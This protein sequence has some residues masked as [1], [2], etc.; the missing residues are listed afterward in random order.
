AVGF[1]AGHG[2][3]QG[4]TVTAAG[5]TA[6]A[7][8]TSTNGGSTPVSVVTGYQ[9]LSST[10]IQSFTGSFSAAMYWAAGIAAF[11]AGPLTAPSDDFSISASPAS[12]SL[13]AG[14]GGTTTIS[15]AVTS[16]SVQTVGLSLSGLPAGATGSFNPSAVTAGGRARL[17]ISTASSTPGGSYTLTVTGTGTTATHTTTVGLTVSPS[18]D[19][20]ISASPASLSLSAGQGGTT[21]ITT[22]V[23]S[24]SAQT[25]S[26]SLSGL[27][28]G[29][30]GSFNPS[31]VTAGGS[32]TLSISTASS[33]PGGSYTLTV[34]GTGT[35]ATHTTTVGLTVSPSDDFSISASPAS[36]SLSA[37]QGGTTTIS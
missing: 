29:A 34:T 21:T 8:Q 26:L 13:S 37:G 20:S 32:S 24:G 23:T 22:A 9:V 14:Q 35:T 19:F 6:Q 12:L 17:G 1:I 2:S 18:D 25:V 31:A 27:P 16:G 30:T 4:I 10:A 11:K 33:T 36:Q 28:A 15:T 3:T 7:Q 5:Y